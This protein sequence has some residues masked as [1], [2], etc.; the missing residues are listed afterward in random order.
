[1]RKALFVFAELLAV[2]FV[3]IAVEE[4]KEPEPRIV[5]GSEAK[6]LP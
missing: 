3:S 1:M 6:E 2:A 5:G 4:I